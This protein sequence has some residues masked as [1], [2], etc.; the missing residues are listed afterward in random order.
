MVLWLCL[1]NF[2]H[3]TV[4]SNRE[5]IQ[6]TIVHKGKNNFN[7]VLFINVDL[8]IQMLV[9]LFGINMHNRSCYVKEIYTNKLTM[10]Q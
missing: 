8:L 5:K 7:T 4:Q 1:L 9:Y 10:S 6:Y 2:I 3:C